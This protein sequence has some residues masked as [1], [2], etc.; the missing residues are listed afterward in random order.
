MRRGLVAAVVAVVAAL[1]VTASASQQHSDFYKTVES[2]R[3]WLAYLPASGAGLDLGPVGLNAED[4]TGNDMRRVDLMDHGRDTVASLC[5]ALT[6]KAVLEACPGSTYL[7]RATRRSM[8]LPAMS[9]IDKGPG[10]RNWLD[11]LSS[12]TPRLADVDYLDG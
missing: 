6:E 1:G 10:S 4:A 2:D 3:S 9:Q 5:F 12:P 11:L 8:D 7:G